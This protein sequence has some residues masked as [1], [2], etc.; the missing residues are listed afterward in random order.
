MPSARSDASL[1][2]IMEITNCFA[3]PRETLEDDDYDDL[4]YQNVMVRHLR[5][6]NVDHLVCG[7]YQANPYGSTVARYDTVDFIRKQYLEGNLVDESIIL[8]YDPTRGAKGFLSLKAFRLSSSASKLFKDGELNAEAMKNNRVV[9]FD[10]FF[11]EIPVTIRNSHLISGLMCEIDE[12]MRVDEG[13]QF[14]DMGS[15]TV[16]EKSLQNLMKCVEDVSRYTNHV[17]QTTQRQQQV[18]REN[19]MRVNRGEA[20]LTEEEVNKIVKPFNANHRLDALLNSCQTLN[21][22]QQTSAFASQNIGKLFLA[23]ALQ[24]K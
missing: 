13:K 8:M 23:K 14:L 11:E 19:A 20:P 18:V 12:E 2:S 15:G 6:V 24:E 7:S 5:N 22:C 3:L 21:Y 10:N 9:S 1:A 17:R 16:L 4:E